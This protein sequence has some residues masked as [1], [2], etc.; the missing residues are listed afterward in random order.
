MNPKIP[1]HYPTDL[2]ESQWLLIEPLLPLPQSGAGKPGRPVVD[3]HRMVNGILYVVKSGCQW[4]LLPHEFGAWQTV[5]GYFNRWSASGIWKQVMNHL[6]EQERERQGRTAQP[7]AGCID[8]QSVKTTTQGES[9][10]YDGGKKIKGRKRHILTDTLGLLLC[11][12][13]TSAS[14][15]DRE[16]LKMIIENWFV[17]GVSRIRK[18][19]VDSGYC[20]E[21]LAAWVSGLKKTHKIELDI[22][23][24]EGPGFQLVRK[25]WV[26]E[27][28]FSW[29]F[30]CRRNS[31]DYEVLTRNSEAMI[32]LSMMA[33]LL[34]RLA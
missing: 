7:S 4:R 6:T 28:T 9:V 33:L 21:A 24:R 1:E 23:Q 13:V 20:G 8:S 10:G 25:R 3:R 14:T 32:Q 16:G 11:V 29:L 19:W 30:N 34:K 18:I 26:I 12:V 22:T 5:Y 2:T 27:R 15:G 17:K 31:K